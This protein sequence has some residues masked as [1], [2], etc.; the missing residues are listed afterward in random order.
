MSELRDSS[1]YYSWEYSGTCNL[2]NLRM[3]CS[4]AAA[5]GDMPVVFA[6]ASDKPVAVFALKRKQPFLIY[7]GEKHPGYILLKNS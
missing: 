6:V 2:N 5:S 1:A 4:F 7:G 3:D